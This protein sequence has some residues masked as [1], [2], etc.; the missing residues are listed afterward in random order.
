VR[1]ED[2]AGLAE[3]ELLQRILTS[4]RLVIAKLPKKTRVCLGL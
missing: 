2:P 3:K 1:V 4:Y